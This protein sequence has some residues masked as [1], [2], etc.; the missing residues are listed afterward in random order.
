M[1]L[2]ISVSFSWPEDEDSLF[3]RNVGIYQQVQTSLQARTPTSRVQIMLGIKIIKKYSK[4]SL[5]RTSL[6]QD[7]KRKLYF[8]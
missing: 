7:Y 2:K 8:C 6:N 1:T 5:I 3:L 4:T